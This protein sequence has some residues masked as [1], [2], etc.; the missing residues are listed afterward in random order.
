MRGG[1]KNLMDREGGGGRL[2]KLQN[3]NKKGTF[4]SQKRRQIR[5][6]GHWSKSKKR[7][8]PGKGFFPEGK[9]KV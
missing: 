9:N 3:K 5:G 1:K 6:K 8:G 7:E 2:D 4:G